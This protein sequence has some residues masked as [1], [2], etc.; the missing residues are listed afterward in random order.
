MFSVKP[1]FITG[2]K[3]NKE[4]SI[5]VREGTFGLPES[6]GS[7]PLKRYKIVAK[8]RGRATSNAGGTT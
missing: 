2:F 5:S 1:H 6:R 3:I 4:N 8:K 7:S